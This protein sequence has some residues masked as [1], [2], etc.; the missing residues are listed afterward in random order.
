VRN[1]LE[2]MLAQGDFP[3]EQRALDDLCQYYEVLVLWNK[4]TNLT[5]L[6][7]PQ[8]YVYKHIYD[9]LYAARFFDTFSSLVDVGSGAGFPGLPLKLVY[10]SIK[11]YLMEAAGK[12]IRFLEH[13]CR[14]LD[15]EAKILHSRAE[16]VGRGPLREQFDVATTRAVAALTVIS[17]YCLPLLRQ[18]GLFIALKGPDGGKEG[19]AAQQAVKLLG[20]EIQDIHR[21]SLPTGEGRSI[22]VVEKLRSTPEKFPRRPG[23]PTKRPL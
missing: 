3:I 8:D 20:G 9:S 11:L 10:P 16:E 2:K 12:K 17:E 7:S 4:K 13:C 15:V 1:E 23:I 21:Y 14:E 18:G 19:L 5:A 6:T 22:V